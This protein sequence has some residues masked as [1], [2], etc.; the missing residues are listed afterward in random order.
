MLGIC[1][2]MQLA[3]QA[4]GGEVRNVPSREYGRAR[5]RVLR[6]GELFAAVPAEIDVWMSHG[7]QVLE[8]SDEFVPLAATATCPIAAVKH[9][10]L[11]IYGLQFHP[12]VTHTPEGTKIIGNFL[13]NRLRL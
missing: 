3:C 5:C 6:P 11:P 4:A 7:D 1:Y 2:G 9:R 8:L 10:R 13:Q 12:E